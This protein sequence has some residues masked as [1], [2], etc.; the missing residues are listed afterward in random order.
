MEGVEELLVILTD[1]Q[2]RLVGAQCTEHSAHSTV[3]TAHSTQHT[4]QQSRAKYNTA[5]HSKVQHSRA[6][7][8]TQHIIDCTVSTA[9]HSS[10]NAASYGVSGA[11]YKQG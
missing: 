10:H 1:T 2:R 3:H 11:L 6:L 5:K 7:Y 8:R 4:A 9:P